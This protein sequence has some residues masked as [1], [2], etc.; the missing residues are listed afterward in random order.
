MKDVEKLTGKRK[1]RKKKK[2]KLRKKALKFLKEHK[3]KAY[4]KEELKEKMDLGEELSGLMDDTPLTASSSLWYFLFGG[5]TIE[6]ERED[7]ETYY[8]YRFDWLSLIFGSIMV[9]CA[10]MAIFSLV[11]PWVM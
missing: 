1:E 11:R 3:G 2:K 7:L 4:T 5:P 8:Y 9:F 6:S 10:C